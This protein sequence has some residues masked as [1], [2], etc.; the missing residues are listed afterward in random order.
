MHH[1]IHN[2]A[3]VQHLVAKIPTIITIRMI[4]GNKKPSKSLNLLGLFE[5]TDLVRN[6]I[7][8]IYLRDSS[9][10]ISPLMADSETAPAIKLVFPLRLFTMMTP[11]VPLIPAPTPS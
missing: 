9:F 2:F 7:T 6:A 5:K 11:G 3:V 10:W 8:L 1:C 4:K